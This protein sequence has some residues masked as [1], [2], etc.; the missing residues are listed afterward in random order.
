MKRTR[1]SHDYSRA[2]RWRLGHP[3]KQGRMIHKNQLGLSAGQ[4]HVTSDSTG[5]ESQGQAAA[6]RSD[7]GAVPKHCMDS[8]GTGDRSE[9]K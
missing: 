7:G 8:M 4:G 2:L 1:L 9:G 5:G 6:C 3:V